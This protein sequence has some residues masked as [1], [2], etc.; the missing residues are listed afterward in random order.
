MRLKISKNGNVL[1]SKKLKKVGRDS[2]QPD[3]ELYRAQD[4]KIIT[5]DRRDGVMR[6]VRQILASETPIDGLE[7]IGQL[8][9]L[10]EA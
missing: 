1:F 4:G 5:H 6:L 8:E 7:E 9:E 10:T 2:N 3:I